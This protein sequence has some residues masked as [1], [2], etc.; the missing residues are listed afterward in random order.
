MDYLSERINR[1]EEL[2][3]NM[4]W[5]WHDEA[6][7]VFR[8]V[9]YATWTMSEH[10]PVEV[11][12]RTSEKRI[13]ELAADPA[14]LTAYDTALNVMDADI[15]TSSNWLKENH[16]ELVQNQAAYFSMEFAHKWL[17]N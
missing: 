15:N 2:A 17:F 5:S 8:M 6:R 10:N 3:Y 13:Q 7:T 14:F 1:L 12:R 16:P 9:D 4:W 11:L